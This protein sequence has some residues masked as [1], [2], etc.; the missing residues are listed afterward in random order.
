MSEATQPQPKEEKKRGFTGWI[1]LLLLLLAIGGAAYWWFVL[2]PGD[3]TFSLTFRACDTQDRCGRFKLFAPGYAY[4]WTYNKARLEFIDGSEPEL[5]PVVEKDLKRAEGV[6]AA[7][8]A[9]S[10]GDDGVNRQLSACRSMRLAT[11]LDDAQASLDTRADTYRISLG[12]YDDSDDEFDDTSIQRLVVITYIFETDPGI[13]LNEALKDGLR[14]NLPEALKAILAP[15]VKQLNFT[16]YSC[17]DNEFNVTQRDTIRTDCY[18]EPSR[19]PSRFCSG[20]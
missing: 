5:A 11:L 16:K 8:L 6:I 19:N 17:W 18:R 3:G 14:L 7:G 12:R 2:R 20:F 1:L 15:E 4:A 9:S 10:E 13:N